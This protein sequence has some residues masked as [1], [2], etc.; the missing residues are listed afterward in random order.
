VRLAVSLGLLAAL[1]A[2]AASTAAGPPTPW[3]GAGQ[4]STTDRSDAISAFQIHVVYAIP[5]DGADRFADVVS[6]LDTDEATIDL[7][8]RGQDPTR[9]PRF[10]LA[11]FPGCTSTFGRLDVSFA[12]LPGTAADYGSG[13]YQL[14]RRDL[15]AAGFRDPDKKYLVYYD[16]PPVVSGTGGVICGQSE[17]G[18]PDGGALAYSI[19]YLAGFCGSSLGSDGVTAVT[20]TH[21]LI[22]GLNAL[23]TPGPPHACPG[24]PGHPC[25]SPTDIL[26]PKQTSDVTLA[27][28]VLDVGRDDYYGHAGSW[29]DVQDSPFLAH[30]DSADQAPPS[31]PGGL[32]A[33]S[34]GGTATVSWQPSSDDTDVAG[35]R[36]Y[37]DGVLYGKTDGLRFEDAG[38]GPGRTHVYAVRAFDA[39][40]FLSGKPQIRFKVGTGIVD[41]AGALLRDTVP[42]PAIA[43]I[44]ARVAGRVVVL[45]WPPVTD[46]GGLRGYRIERNGRLYTLVAR[47][48][49]RIPA[50]R[51]RALW[52]VQAV[53]RAGNRGL[54]ARIVVR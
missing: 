33:T 51:V 35:Y 27:G 5:A 22:H 34:R 43:R 37:R 3:C 50:A 14:V 53:D 29:W 17:N 46:G 23:V 41:A 10:D 31:T 38:A 26:Y 24:D 30:L 47:P 20:A 54:P 12:R 13:Q 8:W 6:L 32:T 36:V 9:T 15:D 28:L 4:E 39:A 19:V 44:R 16:G 21:E 42:P 40:G 11:A 18:H 25:D 52:S 48:T 1:V 2:A 49:I 7:W 45:A